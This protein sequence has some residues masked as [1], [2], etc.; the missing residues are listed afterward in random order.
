MKN[1]DKTTFL[2]FMKELIKILN[3]KKIRPYV[4]I[5]DNLSCHKTKELLDYYY[6][7]KIIVIFTYHIFQNLMR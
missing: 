1:T 2:D 4:I 7:N 5:L 6:E 3:D